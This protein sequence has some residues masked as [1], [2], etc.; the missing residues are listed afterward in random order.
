ML[1]GTIFSFSVNH[2]KCTFISSQ[3]SFRSDS[4]PPYFP[5]IL[6]SLLQL[7]LNISVGE[8]RFSVICPLVKVPVLTSSLEIKL[9]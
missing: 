7:H 1:F 5:H 9:Y 3:L 4:L 6:E 8:C 2:E